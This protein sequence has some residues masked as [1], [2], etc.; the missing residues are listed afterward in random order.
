MK[1]MLWVLLLGVAATGV[2]QTPRSTMNHARHDNPKDVSC[3]SAGRPNFPGPEN[4]TFSKDQ[5]GNL[6]NGGLTIT[7]ANSDSV[8]V[9]L[10]MTMMGNGKLE[11]DIVVID[12]L[13]DLPMNVGP[14][15]ENIKLP[16][17]HGKVSCT[18]KT[19]Y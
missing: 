17:F 6:E 4:T 18:V 7:E 3:F 15:G 12:G 14:K 5:V 11:G 2:S 13:L 10:G 8:T 19:W 1:K 16:A 9:F